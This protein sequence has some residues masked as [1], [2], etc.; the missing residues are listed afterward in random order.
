M[1]KFEFFK[2]ALTAISRRNYFR[3][4][5]FSFFLHVFVLSTSY[6]S[7]LFFFNIFLYFSCFTFALSS[8][9]KGFLLSSFNFSF[10]PSFHIFL[11][12]SFINVH[13]IQ[14]SR[15]TSSV[16]FLLSFS[17]FI[18]LLRS[19]FLFLL[20]SY[21]FVF[22]HIYFFTMSF[23]NSSFV[24]FFLLPAYAFFP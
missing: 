10:F 1:T 20:P 9:C 2:M 22:L 21:F 7:C 23:L 6:Y 5:G 18:F 14:G 13:P 4:L 19:H 3:K 17:S 24:F 12:I 15:A 11:L 16:I 8:S